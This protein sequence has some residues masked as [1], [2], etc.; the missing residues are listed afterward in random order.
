MTAHAEAR[1]SGNGQASFMKRAHIEGVL[2]DFQA[3]EFSGTAGTVHVRHKL[4]EALRLLTSRPGE[5]V[6]RGEL[7][8]VLWSGRAVSDES[9]T[10]LMSELR[11]A[12]VR[13][14]TA[15]NVIQTV[16]KNGYRLIGAISQEAESTRTVQNDAGSEPSV[17]RL[18]E[19]RKIIYFVLGFAIIVHAVLRH[20]PWDLF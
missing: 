17:S 3:N 9:V 8:S 10:Q 7:I 1:V 20:G 2:V 13:A 5:V 6:T 16:P 4:L 15:A 11:N 18:S 19:H 12:F 14:G